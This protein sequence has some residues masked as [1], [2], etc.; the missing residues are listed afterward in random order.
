MND[1]NGKH[2]STQNSF[3]S[4]YGAPSIYSKIKIYLIFFFK[5][6]PTYHP[7]KV[8]LEPSAAALFWSTPCD[9]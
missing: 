2:Y 8:V 6:I 5:K 7:E 9:A 4:T 3:A 1:L